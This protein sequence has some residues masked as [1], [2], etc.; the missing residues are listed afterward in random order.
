MNYRK[1]YDS[2]IEKRRFKE[3]IPQSEPGENHHFIPKCMGGTETVR[4]TIRE[5]IFAHELLVMIYGF[6]EYDKNILIKMLTAIE[7]M[8]NL[9]S[10]QMT[11]IGKIYH[12]SRAIEK[13]IL[14]YRNIKATEYDTKIRKIYN[15][16]KTYG[17][18]YIKKHYKI[19]IH[20]LY[21]QWRKRGL[22]FKT[23][24][25]ER[26]E[27]VKKFY[28]IWKETGWENTF[29]LMGIENTRYNRLLWGDT[30]RRYNPDE[31]KK[32]SKKS[33]NEKY[34]LYLKMAKDFNIYGFEYIVE[35]YNY[36]YP[37]G[38][39][40]GY[41]NKHKIY[42]KNPIEDKPHHTTN[43]TKETKEIIR[44]NTLGRIWVTNGIELHQIKKE[45]LNEYIQK[46][47]IIGRKYKLY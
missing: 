7:R 40:Y 6:E 28:N 2:L 34:E 30:F 39:F 22:V 1:I 33:I 32:L 11:T 4:L 26:A 42:H 3:I 25:E 20:R 35:K 31:K 29:K 10:Q 18:N 9:K 13:M 23:R 46:G 38:V 36:K 15:D 5:H 27:Y 8:C 14:K 17:Y 37:I 44:Q 16:Y 19:K 24:A 47:Y 21:D 41:C 43:H 12:K 45:D